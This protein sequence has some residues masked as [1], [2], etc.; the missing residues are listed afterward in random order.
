M[1]GAEM[2]MFC[3]GCTRWGFIGNGGDRRADITGCMTTIRRWST[4]LESKLH[5]VQ[6]RVSGT[7]DVEIISGAYTEE[8]PEAIH[9]I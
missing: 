9:R 8:P 4:K 5:S 3:S 6:G 7:G 1:E 2:D